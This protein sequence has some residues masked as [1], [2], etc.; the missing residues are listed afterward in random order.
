MEAG[1]IVRVS[2]ET[3]R[4]VYANPCSKIGYSLNSNPENFVLY[5]VS[6]IPPKSVLAGMAGSHLIDDG[7]PH[8]GGCLR[9]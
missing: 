8:F 9:L 4:S 3:R 1:D 7:V 5:V 2:P 6:A